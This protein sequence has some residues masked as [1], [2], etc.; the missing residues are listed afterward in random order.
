MASRL[1]RLIR[2]V[3]PQQLV[4]RYMES[5]IPLPTDNIYKF[6][7]LFSLLLLISGIGLVFYSTNNTNSII[8]EHWVEIES[9]QSI[10]KPTV[11]QE[12]RLKALER[13]VEVAVSDKN[14]LRWASFGMVM[15]GTFGVMLGFGY[16]HKHIQPVADQMARTQLEIARLQLLN[17]KADLKAKGVDADAV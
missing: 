6:F 9:L 8:F 15:L 5:K 14:A 16:W 2:F 1:R 12:S 3:L 7:A 4:A 13:K 11:E 10:E 17:L